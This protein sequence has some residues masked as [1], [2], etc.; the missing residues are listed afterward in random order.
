MYPAPISEYYLP[1]TLEDA[2][3]M[4]KDAEGEVT[5]MAGGMSLMQAIKSR[6]ITP[7]CIIDLNRIQELKGISID[8][9]S[10]TI[11]AMTR[12]KDVAAGRN[13]LLTYEALCDAAEHVGDRQ[14]RNRGTVGGSL[15][16][17]YVSACTP[18]ASL[19]TGAE[20]EILRAGNG[21]TEKLVIDDFLRG[22]M[23]TALEEGD[24]LLSIKLPKSSAAAGSAYKKW[25]VVKDALPVIGVGI[26][27]E[28]NSTDKCCSA[29]FAVG[30]LADGPQRS[31]NAEQVLMDGNISDSDCLQEALVAAA[32]EI[33]TV[34]DP[35][36]SAEYRSH[37]INSLG[38][39]VLE[40]SLN[41]ARGRLA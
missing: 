26:Y 5:F 16:W 40:T 14:V 32:N 33:E 25:G 9:N 13:H 29:R 36:I 24:L 17:N 34:S 38:A 35:W 21:N 7:D 1:T 41:L 27:V 19:A 37:L 12:Y 28:L 30:G 18:V 3:R 23:E 8:D 11:G 39:E 6:L 2:I 15:C 20:L 22:P 10:I 31:R 4:Y